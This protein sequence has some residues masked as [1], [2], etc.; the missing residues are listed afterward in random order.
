MDA[1]IRILKFASGFDAITFQNLFDYI[2]KNDIRFHPEYKITESNTM[3]I[4]IF[5]QDF[6]RENGDKPVLNFQGQYYLRPEALTYLLNYESLTAAREDAKSARSEALD[7]N[8]LAKK[9]VN[10]AIASIL[11]TAVLTLLQIYLQLNPK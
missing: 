3:L 8:K 7:A 6:A 9:A 2:R 5:R 11:I 10:I 4:N 1:Y